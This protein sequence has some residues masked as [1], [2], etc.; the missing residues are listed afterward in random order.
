ML[1]Y[2][3]AKDVYQVFVLS[4]RFDVACHKLVE[5]CLEK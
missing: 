1:T 4:R 5:L 2:V 3:C